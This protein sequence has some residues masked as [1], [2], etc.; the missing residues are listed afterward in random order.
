M[1]ILKEDDYKVSGKEINGYISLYDS[2][3]KLG[4]TL[5]TKEYY[6][7]FFYKNRGKSHALNGDI[8]LQGDN[9]C[10]VYISNIR[11][12]PLAILYDVNVQ[13]KRDSS[14]YYPFSELSSVINEEM[15]NIS[16]AVRLVDD[17]MNEVL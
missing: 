13:F 3:E 6:D 16:Q 11:V 14:M 15:D 1:K 9:M 10:D 5:D 7:S 8:Y 12:T 2:L 4:Y 17:Y